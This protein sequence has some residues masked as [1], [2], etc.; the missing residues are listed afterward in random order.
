[1]NRILKFRVWDAHK[2]V[3]IYQ[4]H[5]D[6]IYK[7]LKYYDQNIKTTLMQYT[8][9]KDKHKKEIY[10]DDILKQGHTIWVVRITTYGVVAD[11]ING[12]RC[13]WNITSWADDMEIIG[14]MYENT[15]I[16]EGKD[17]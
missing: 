17:E 13:N 15:E 8:E 16:L 14:N 10:E 4:D 2:K 3:M 6:L 9:L 12:T 7:C 5:T 11:T 1:M